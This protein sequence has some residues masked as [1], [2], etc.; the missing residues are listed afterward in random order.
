MRATQGDIKT[1]QREMESLYKHC[2]R[3]LSQAFMGIMW[4]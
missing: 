1:V 2:L 4:P 3:A